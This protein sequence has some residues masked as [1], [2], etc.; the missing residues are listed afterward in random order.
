MGDRL[1]YGG[2]CKQQQLFFESIHSIEDCWSTFTSQNWDSYFL[3]RCNK[4]RQA[5][6]TIC[7]W[8]IKRAIHKVWTPEMR[9]TVRI[10]ILS[11]I[12]RVLASLQACFR[13]FV[14]PFSSIPTCRWTSSWQLMDDDETR[15]FSE[16][17]GRWRKVKFMVLVVFPAST[18]CQ[19]LLVNE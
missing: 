1:N 14:G 9:D 15:K 12:Q 2:K 3:I 16:D 4:P 8:S 7:W 18:I 6:G 17:C 19:V 13:S 5:W 10:W 11:Q